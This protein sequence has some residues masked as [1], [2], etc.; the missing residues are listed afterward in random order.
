M[1]RPGSPLNVDR[2]VQ[3]QSALAR[4]LRGKPVPL[5]EVD[6]VEPSF[7]C[8]ECSDTR[9]V[10]EVAFDGTKRSRR[11]GGCRHRFDAELKAKASRTSIEVPDE[12][13]PK[14]RDWKKLTG[15]DKEE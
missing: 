10:V 9:F 7:D 15:F 8:C 11:C 5:S 14:I 3:I 12:E 1:S 2:W 6:L 4:A 13:P